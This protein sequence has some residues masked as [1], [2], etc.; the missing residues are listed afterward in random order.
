VRICQINCEIVDSRRASTHTHTKQPSICYNIECCH[1]RHIIFIYYYSRNIH[2]ERGMNKQ[3]HTRAL[4]Q[5]AQGGHFDINIYM[6]MASRLLISSQYVS[7][8]KCLARRRTAQWNLWA[9]RNDDLAHAN[10]HR[11][12]ALWLRPRPRLM[13]SLRSRSIRGWMSELLPSIFHSQLLLPAVCRRSTLRAN[14][15]SPARP[16]YRPCKC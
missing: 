13:K 3:T 5:S 9:A 16:N 4:Y 12:G 8:G 11:R 2:T 10:E 1:T 6:C 15:N 14:N 7:D